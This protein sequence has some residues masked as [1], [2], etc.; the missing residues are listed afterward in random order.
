MTTCDIFVFILTLTNA[1][2]LGWVLFLSSRND[3][4]KGYIHRIETEE[5]I[6]DWT[7]DV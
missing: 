7:K 5:E 6:T 2:T 1:G 3:E 4:M